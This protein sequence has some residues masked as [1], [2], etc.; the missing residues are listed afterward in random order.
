MNGRQERSPRRIGIASHFERR[1]VETCASPFFVR[2]AEQR[3][4]EIRREEHGEEESGHRKTGFPPPGRFSPRF[5]PFRPV[6]ARPK[7]GFDKTLSAKYIWRIPG[8][9]K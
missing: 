7:K 8:K 6:S 3:G 5:G 4:D 1:R 9:Q 2:H